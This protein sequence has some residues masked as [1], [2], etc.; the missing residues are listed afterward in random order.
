MINIYFLSCNSL[1]SSYRTFRYN[2]VY[3]VQSLVF[4]GLFSVWKSL[5]ITFISVCPLC[6]KNRTT[7]P[8]SQSLLSNAFELREEDLFD[9]F[10]E[11]LP[12]SMYL[13]A[14]IEGDV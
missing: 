4:Y 1:D 13:V 11:Q 8:S 3:L 10:S 5:V 14:K 2:I 12:D 7:S 6:G 9:L